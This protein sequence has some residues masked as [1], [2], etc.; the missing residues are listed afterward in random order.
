MK[1]KLALALALFSTAA[2][3]ATTPPKVVFIGDFYTYLWSNAFASNPNWI[4][5]GADGL[6][7]VG[8]GE[9]SDETLA[10]FP[11]DVVALHP[12]IV[13][14]MI[15]INDSLNPSPSSLPGI[16]PF[17]ESNL[18]KMVKEAQAANIKVVLG[19]EPLD[20]QS[21]NPELALINAAVAAYGAVNHIPVVNYGDTLCGCTIEGGST[22]AGTSINVV[23]MGFTTDPKDQVDGGFVPSATGYALMTQ[24]AETAIATLNNPSLTLKSGYLQDIQA[25]SPGVDTGGQTNVNNVGTGS[26]LQFTPY[27]SFSD[28]SLHV[29]SN[30]TSGSNNYGTWSSSNPLVMSVTQEGLAFA[31]TPGT[32]IIHFTPTNGVHISEWIMTVYYSD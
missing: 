29:L 17:V 25:P 26:L 2:S 1:L 30:T 11:S 7:I 4:N 27:G 32:T 28:G 6:G 8:G 12:A 22:G 18:D 23:N 16:P 3:A 19:L 24:M 14:I 20:E 21:G 13:H 9:T 15:G 10:R 31:T 5:K